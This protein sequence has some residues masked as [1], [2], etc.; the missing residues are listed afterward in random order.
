MSEW[1]F[2]AESIR[3][4]FLN[5]KSSIPAISLV[6]TLIVTILFLL[7]NILVLVKLEHYASLVYR[8][9]YF[10]TSIIPKIRN[11]LER[12][13][14]ALSIQ[15][16]VNG[17]CDQ[18]N[19][20]SSDILPHAMKIEWV[21]KE[22]P[23][24]FVK[25]GQ[26]VVRLRHYANQDKNIVDAALLYLKIGLLPR[27][28]TC[29]DKY[30]RKSCEFKVASQIFSADRKTGA[31]DYFYEN[32]LLPAIGADIRIRNDLQ[33]IDD[34]DSVGYFAPLFLS[35]V[36]HVGEK[37]MAAVPNVAIQQEI[38]D[39]ANFLEVI[40]NKG[41]QERVP[42]TFKGLKIKVAVVLVATK[43]TIDRYDISPYVN[44][45]YIHVREGYDSIYISGWGGLFSKKVIE[46]KNEVERNLVT[47]IKRYD[48]VIRNDRKGI[49][50]ECQSNIGY[51]AERRILQE[52]TKTIMAEI[53]PEIKNGEVEIISIARK[54]NVGCK[55]AVRATSSEED[56][57]L[58]SAFMG[59]AGQRF[60]ELKRR[61]C[62]NFLGIIPWSDDPKKF[63]AK[64]LHP[65]K[66]RYINSI[67]IDEEN[68]IANVEVSTDD[69]YNK[70]MGRDGN[71]IDLA[72]ELTGWLINV[73]GLKKSSIVQSPEDEL[74]E[75]LSANIPE[76]K[77]GEI[78][79]VALSR[80]EGIGS[81]IIVRWKD[82][83]KREWASKVCTGQDNDILRKLHQDLSGEWIYF[84][85]W[86]AD[87]KELIASCLFPLKRYEITSVDIDRNNSTAY[88]TVDQQ[89]KTSEL[90]KSQYN[91]K[92][93]E[94]VT[95]WKIKIRELE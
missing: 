18:I 51:L 38:R 14:V 54:R 52:E 35:E 31:Y 67:D 2:A 36:K 90:W 81:R 94:K 34:I 50:I 87:P 13:T 48:S 58:I 26:V 4:F 68:L 85:E 42:L 15:D 21:R 78:E 83:D 7:L 9:L 77:N 72:R 76:I 6:P 22:D 82:T 59:D 28:R 69:A 92:L 1:I 39:F 41:A 65:L 27:A 66:E 49:L 63:I 64:A 93:C 56:Y 53:I 89:E 60:E 29:L 45:I 5:I 61:L 88:I 10:L 16:S 20:N 30:L 75:M 43:E 24:S 71:N 12:H 86:N 37:L 55:I 95:G 80:I 44:A 73:R 91:L 40:A 47:V 57:D 79:I 19:K 8:A 17:I 70:A 3:H 23:E 32:E 25:K 74:R 11:K 84:H 46:I 33:M 62:A